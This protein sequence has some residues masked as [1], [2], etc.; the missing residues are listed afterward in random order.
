M[1]TLN[2]ELLARLFRNFK[3]KNKTKYY[4][5]LTANKYRLVAT[6]LDLKSVIIFDIP[7]QQFTDDSTVVCFE[8]S[9]EIQNLL[10]NFKLKT[11]NTELQIQTLENSVNIR[12]E[13]VLNVELDN[14]DIKQLVKTKFVFTEK[15]EFN[16]FSNVIQIIDFIPVK[17]DSFFISDFSNCFDITNQF[18]FKTDINFSNISFLLENPLFLSNTLSRFKL[19]DSTISFSDQDL[20]ISSKSQI[21]LKDKSIVDITVHYNPYLNNYSNYCEIT[22]TIDLLLAD[23][24]YVELKLNEDKLKFLANLSK[25]EFIDLNS[26]FRI[27]VDFFN[28]FIK[29]NLDI[30]TKISYVDNLIKVEYL[31]SDIKLTVLGTIYQKVEYVE[32][33]EVSEYTDDLL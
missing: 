24:V 4:I 8:V 21:K 25:E 28:R 30:I 19:T 33:E 31:I 17:I 14:L 23:K 15:V 10:D 12:Y 6:D 5:Y 27:S 11:I 22:K 1:Y 32:V 3:N 7:E 20:L 2:L 13:D 29:N 9:L 18:Y 16:Q 26:N